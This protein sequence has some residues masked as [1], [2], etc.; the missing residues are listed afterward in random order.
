[1][2]VAQT[3]AV[4][5]IFQSDEIKKRILGRINFAELI[6]L[7]QTSKQFGMFVEDEIWRTVDEK[8]Y[9]LKNFEKLA[10]KN[11]RKIEVL[12]L[13]GNFKHFSK[14]F[15]EIMFQKME[16]LESIIIKNFYDAKKFNHIIESLSAQPDSKLKK[17][18]INYVNNKQEYE[19]T[20]LSISKLSQLKNLKNFSIADTHVEQ[21]EI[22]LMI[23]KLESPNIEELTI[24]SGSYIE[25]ELYQIIQN[26]YSKSLKILELRKVSQE[27]MEDFEKLVKSLINLEKLYLSEMVTSFGTQILS[28]VLPSDL[29]KLNT[30]QINRHRY[31]NQFNMFLNHNWSSIKI[32]VLNGCVLSQETS[33]I[34]STQFQSVDVLDLVELESRPEDYKTILESIGHNLK[35]LQLVAPRFAISEAW[36]Q[37]IIFNKLK[38]ISIIGTDLN[39][40]IISSIFEKNNI[41]EELTLESLFLN[42][43]EKLLKQLESLKAQKQIDSSCLKKI[44]LFNI[45]W[46]TGK[47]LRQIID[48]LN[49]NIKNIY[50]EE[51]DITTEEIRILSEA[52]PLINLSLEIKQFDEYA[53]NEDEDTF[54]YSQM[55]QNKL[56]MYDGNQDY[57]KP[58]GGWQNNMDF[59]NAYPIKNNENKRNG[60]DCS[61]EADDGYFSDPVNDVD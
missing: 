28:S 7:Q 6:Q 46:L 50:I 30:L 23:K 32:L 55:D 1:M 17:I 22:T 42:N 47:N 11:A 53:S 51:C 35:V 26:K 56:N 29:K 41:L 10:E 38:K 49:I 20:Q 36:P 2:P 45:P 4:C 34:I 21:K 31:K 19:K 60:Y 16:K 24:I 12:T 5:T 43:P 9:A 27:T 3:P 52:F 14:E 33:D 40:V 61:K 8:H 13:D 18:E 39:P 57:Q 59:N 44:E 37:K 54:D 25:K 48:S 15:V 58:T